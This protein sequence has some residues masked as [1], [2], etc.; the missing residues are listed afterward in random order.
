MFNIKLK[1]PDDLDLAVINLT[2]II[3]TA[4]WSA[5]ASNVVSPITNPLLLLPAQIRSNIVEKQRARALYQRTR[6]HSHKQNYNHLANA[7]KKTVAK[8]KTSVFHNHHSNL[9]VKDGSL[10]RATKQALKYKTTK[11]PN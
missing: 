9:T 7:L 3:Q 11:L 5:S 4:A 2:N 1:T 6:L 8:H 10:W